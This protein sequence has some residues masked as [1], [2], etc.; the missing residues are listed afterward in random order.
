MNPHRTLLI[1]K[2]DGYKRNLLIPVLSDLAARASAQAV[3]IET[4][5]LTNRDVRLLYGRYVGEPFYEPLRL[6]MVSG[7][8]MIMELVGNHAVKRVRERVGE[9]NPYSLGTIRARYASSIRRRN[10][11][12]CSDSTKTAARELGYFFPKEIS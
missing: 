4:R 2:P 11:V 7:P 5:Y 6:F 8:S 1:L 12:H 9:G 10:V 3:R